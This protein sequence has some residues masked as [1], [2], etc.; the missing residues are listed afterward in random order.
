M[1]PQAKSPIAWQRYGSQQKHYAVGAGICEGHKANLDGQ[2]V[3]ALAVGYFILVLDNNAVF[4]C[5]KCTAWFDETLA[6][7]DVEVNNA[8]DAA[9]DEADSGYCKSEVGAAGKTVVRFKVAAPTPGRCP[10]L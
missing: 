9:N 6:R 10:V 5:G 7:G 4:F 3:N 2:F 8:E 1:R